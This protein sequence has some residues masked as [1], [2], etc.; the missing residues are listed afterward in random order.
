ME[1]GRALVAGLVKRKLTLSPSVTRTTGPGNWPL[2]VHAANVVPSPSI[3]TSVSIAFISK[4]IVFA[5]LSPTAHPIVT[6]SVRMPKILADRRLIAY[7]LVLP[8]TVLGRIVQMGPP[9]T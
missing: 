3:T 4:L 1:C 2:N 8:L 6:A 9:E 7:L 5:W